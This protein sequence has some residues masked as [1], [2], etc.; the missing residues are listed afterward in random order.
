VTSASADVDTN[1]KGLISFYSLLEK[2]ARPRT[3]RGANS[4]CDVAHV[5]FPQFISG[6]YR[7]FPL[8][9]CQSR[10]GYPMRA[11]GAPPPFRVGFGV[12][13]WFC[14]FCLRR[15]IG[16]NSGI[17]CWGGTWHYAG[18]DMVGLGHGLFY[19]ILGGYVVLLVLGATIGSTTGLLHDC[20]RGSALY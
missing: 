16:R 19:R 10:S 13:L 14:L 1:F 6:P 7:G 2:S 15:D 3:P 8:Y 9:L 20:L 4:E 17:H 12:G 5:G 18:L 11:R